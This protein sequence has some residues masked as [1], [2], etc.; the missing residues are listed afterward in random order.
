METRYFR[1]LHE[2]EQFSLRELLMGAVIADFEHSTMSPKGLS[3]TESDMPA[4]IGVLIAMLA[5]FG[6]GPPG[7]YCRY[8]G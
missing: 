2:A 7:N 1:F 4:V 5:A 8:N 3:V 6:C